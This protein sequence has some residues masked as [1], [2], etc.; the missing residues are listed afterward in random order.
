MRTQWR[1]RKEQCEH[2]EGFSAEVTSTKVRREGVVPTE[3]VMSM[4]LGTHEWRWEASEHESCQGALGVRR[5]ESRLS[6]EQRGYGTAL[7]EDPG[8]GARVDNARPWLPG[9]PSSDPWIAGLSQNRSALRKDLCTW[10]LF[11]GRAWRPVTWAPPKSWLCWG[12]FHTCSFTQTCPVPVV[13]ALQVGKL[14]QGHLP[15]G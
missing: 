4:S 1:W 6:R 2:Q 5:V 13:P 7:T 8:A 15:M 3:G 11:G 9:M 10:A 12:N 14:R